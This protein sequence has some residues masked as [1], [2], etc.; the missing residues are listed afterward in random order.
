MKTLARFSH[1]SQSISQNSGTSCSPCQTTIPGYPNLF[2]LLGA[3]VAAGIC[4]WWRGCFESGKCFVTDA[5]V[6]LGVGSIFDY[7]M[8]I[9]TMDLDPDVSSFCW[10]PMWPQESVSGG[11]AASNREN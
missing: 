8:S 4:Q 2:V 6:H 11:V 5:V 9:S 7:G 10:G 1:Q 3:N